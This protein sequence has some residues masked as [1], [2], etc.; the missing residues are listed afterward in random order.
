MQAPYECHENLATTNYN[1]PTVLC[2]F[3]LSLKKCTLKKVDAL[4]V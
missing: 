1:D 3:K 4:L 2:L